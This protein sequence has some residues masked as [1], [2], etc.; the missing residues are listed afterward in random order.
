MIFGGVQD[1]GITPVEV[2]ACGTP[3]IALNGGGAK[4]TVIDG[5]TGVLYDEDTPQSIIKGIEKFESIEFDT[6]ILRKHA[7]K[8]SR[9]RFLKEIKEEIRTVLDNYDLG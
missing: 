3:V 1:F 6:K 8:F 7:E 9:A 5:K 2:M 4:E